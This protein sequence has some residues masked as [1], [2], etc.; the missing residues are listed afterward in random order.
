[1]EYEQISKNAYCYITASEVEG[2]SP[3]LLAAMGF[4]TAVLVS[5]IPE[6]I[7]TIEDS[8]FTFEVN[9]FQSLVTKIEYLINNP[10]VVKIFY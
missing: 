8:G 5:S 3:A 1:M 6:N 4:S 10:D 2:T 9:N 7:E